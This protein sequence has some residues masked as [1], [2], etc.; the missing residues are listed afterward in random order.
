[1]IVLVLII[2]AIGL[3]TLALIPIGAWLGRPDVVKGSA[4]IVAAVIVA[5]FAIA[6]MNPA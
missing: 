6:A 3:F 4:I 5:I 2:A 1:M